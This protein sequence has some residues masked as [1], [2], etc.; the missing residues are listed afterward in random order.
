M[1][2]RSPAPGEMP[3]VPTTGGHGAA[4]VSPD[5]AAA[6]AEVAATKTHAG[7]KHA[8]PGAP[9]E[10]PRL[11][12]V[13][14]YGRMGQA[15]RMLRV[16]VELSGDEAPPQVVAVTSAVSGEG[17]TTT[18]IGLA[19]A[20]V[21]AGRRVILLECDLY[22]PSM[23][24]ELP[25]P[26][27][28]QT[29]VSVILDP[30]AEVVPTRIDGL[31]ILPA[32]IGIENPVELLQPHVMQ[33]LLSR[34][35]LH[36]DDIV[37]DT[38]PATAVSDSLVIGRIAD[39]VVLVMNAQRTDKEA[40]RTLRKVLEQWNVPVLGVA[41]NRGDKVMGGGYYGYGY[42]YEDDETRAARRQAKKS[43]KAAKR[44]GTGP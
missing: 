36:Y 37:I 38:A 29:I 12:Q 3:A 43:K 10:E 4:S 1:T 39:G 22:R 21:M 13:Q 35:R 41:L 27:D 5:P 32:P 2:P 15:Y 24:K 16:G 40:H 33:K 8:R 9:G 31:D 7:A 30:D 44:A 19:M 6:A 14:T 26:P 28:A 17:K 11:T 18:S 25:I 23:S 34:L 20:S 42:G